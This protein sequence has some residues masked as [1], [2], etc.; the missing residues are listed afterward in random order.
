MVAPNAECAAAM[1]SNFM[2]VEPRIRVLGAAYRQGLRV[3]AD[4]RGR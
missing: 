1:G 2:D 3:A 4:G